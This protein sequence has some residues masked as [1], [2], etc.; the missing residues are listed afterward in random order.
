MM[1]FL[2]IIVLQFVIALVVLYVLKRLLDRELQKAAIEKFMSLKKSDAVSSIS[3]YYAGSLSL[4]IQQDLTALAKQKFG[5]AKVVFEQAQAL[6][7]GLVIQVAE[8]ILDFSLTTRL[9]NFWS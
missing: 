8:E 6:K 1:P 4:N 5:Q 3:V 2:I 9:E 7:G